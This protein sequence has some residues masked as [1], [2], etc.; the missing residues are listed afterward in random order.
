M[1][2]FRA[3]EIAEPNEAS[4]KAEN[5]S[6]KTRGGR[7]GAIDVL[8]EALFGELFRISRVNSFKRRKFETG[9]PERSGGSRGPP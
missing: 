6:E 5:Q 2:L 1:H 8:C 7:W 4:M 9:L 3:R